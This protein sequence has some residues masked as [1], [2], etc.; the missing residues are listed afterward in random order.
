MG[1]GQHQQSG[2]VNLGPAER[3]VLEDGA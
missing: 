1:S 2:L 3:D